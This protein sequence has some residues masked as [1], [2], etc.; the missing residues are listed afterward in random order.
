MFKKK[1]PLSICVTKMIYNVADDRL[2]LYIHYTY[3]LVN[4]NVVIYNRS[5]NNNCV[6][7]HVFSFRFAYVRAL[8]VTYPPM[9]DVFTYLQL[10]FHK[11][12]KHKNCTWMSALSTL[13]VFSL[14]DAQHTKFTFNRRQN[15]PYDIVKF[16][17]STDYMN[18]IIFS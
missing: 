3:I 13:I 9:Y 1:I 12:Q 4:Y 17:T 5:F 7:S 15:Q 16:S 2:I 8:L 6:D 14:I 18:M 10:F 11:R